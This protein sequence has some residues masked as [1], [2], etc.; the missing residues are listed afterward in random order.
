MKTIIEL[1]LLGFKKQLLHLLAQQMPMAEFEDLDPAKTTDLNVTFKTAEAITTQNNTL[2]AGSTV[3][4]NKIT[5]T[6]N[7]PDKPLKET[8][9][10]DDD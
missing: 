5:I 2:A 4:I 9:E 1:D 8:T 10:E 6:V 7:V 3:D